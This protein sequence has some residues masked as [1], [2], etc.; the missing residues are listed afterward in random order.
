MCVTVYVCF[1]VDWVIADNLCIKQSGYGGRVKYILKDTVKYLP[2]FG[3][4]LGDVS[5][6]F[7]C[8][9]CY[10]YC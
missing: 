1:S 6:C 4:Q 2:I 3:W 10:N 7:A 5:C 8:C 9:E